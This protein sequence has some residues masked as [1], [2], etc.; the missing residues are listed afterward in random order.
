MTRTKL[1][2][3]LK[4]L[5]TLLLLAVSIYFSIWKVDFAELGRSFSTA[6]YWLGLAIVP[7]ILASHL[8]RAVRWKVILRHIHPE[9]RLGNLFAGVMVGYFMN[10]LIM[11][12]GEVVRPYTT[13][14]VEPGTTFASLLGS[15]VV[16]RFIDTVALLI[17]IAGIMLVD[18][19]LFDGFEDVGVSSAIIRP[20]IYTAIV[21]GVGFIAVAP[22]RAGLWMAETATLPLDLLA[23]ATGIARLAA[24]R[25]SV[26][27]LFRKLQLGFGALRSAGQVG[28]VLLYTAAMYLCYMLPLYMMFFAFPSGWHVSPTLLDATKIWAITALAWAVAPTPGAFGVFHVTCRIAIMKILD[29]TYADAVAYATITHFV[30][31]MVPLLL[32]GWYLL[33]TNLSMRELLDARAKKS[34]GEASA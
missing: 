25:V 7:V 20:I 16:E 14:R 19:R 34:S 10:N 15:I 33:R 1:L 32:G 6:N 18:A 22:S 27:D 31:Y 4:I 11:R 9:V 23:R 3:L 30:N 29:F 13:A 2:S 24:L 8:F 17:V 21:L 28:I 12:S 5:A 26:L